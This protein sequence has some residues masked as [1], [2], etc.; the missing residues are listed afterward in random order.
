MEFT[1][2]GK[3]IK[4]RRDVRNYVIAGI[5]ALGLIAFGIYHLMTPSYSQVNIKTTLDADHVDQ[6]ITANTAST[7]NIAPD[8]LSP[9]NL[10]VKVNTP[11][12][13][14]NDDSINES[15]VFSDG[16][17][18]PAIAPHKSFTT[19]FITATDVLYYL[20]L[21]PQTQGTITVDD[22]GF[23]TLKQGG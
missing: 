5:A 23:T 9:S 22:P 1:I 12:T 13:W 21:H 17:T 18:S 8:L 3:T 11:V 15:L 7:I 6:L 10:T 20:Q 2:T 14:V 4:I 16:T 19:T